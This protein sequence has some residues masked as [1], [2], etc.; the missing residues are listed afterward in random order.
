M[1]ALAG[2]DEWYLSSPLWS[3]VGVVIAVVA[4]IVGERVTRRSAHPR[5]RLQ[6]ACSS[7]VLLVQSPLGAESGIEVRHRG[8][9]LARPHAATLTLSWRGPRDV[10]R[11]AFDGLPL[12]VDLGTPVVTLVEQHSYP[13]RT[14]ISA[15][16]VKLTASGLEI[17]PALL[18]RNH[19]L[20]YTVI[21]D[22]EPDLSVHGNLADVDIQV[23]KLP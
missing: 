2:A 5:T 13:G 8:R 23:R 3:I 14:G 11:D 1:Q 18:G 10:P 9:V 17:G 7:T 21:V 16:P 22:G 19:E 6:V 12:T 20:S 4:I 15:P